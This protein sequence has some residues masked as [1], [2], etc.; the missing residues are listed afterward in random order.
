DFR[1]VFR[2]TILGQNA[3]P[4]H[5]RINTGATPN[6]A[7]GIQDRVTPDVR[8]VPKQRAEFAEAGVERHT[9]LFDRHISR[10]NFYVGNFDSGAQVRFVAE[11]G[12]TYVIEVRDLAI[13]E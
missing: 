7:A 10:N 4:V 3:A 8:V 12:I 13:V 9:V 2:D 6:D 5:V 1:F 11:N